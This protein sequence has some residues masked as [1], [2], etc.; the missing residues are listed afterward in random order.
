L[1]ELLPFRHEDEKTLLNG[2]H[3]LNRLI[4]P[5]IFV[6]PILYRNDLYLI[7]TLILITL[8]IGLICRL[9][10][11][12]IFSRLKNIVPF[13]ILITIFI[14]LYV[15]KSNFV[16][17]NIGIKIIIYKE[18]LNLAF[19]LFSRIFG[20]TF[21]FMS[22]YSSFTYSEFIEALSKLRIPTFFI[23]SLMI[24]LHYIPIFAESNKK[25]LEAQEL[26]GKKVTSYWQRLKAHAYIMGKNLVHNMEKSEKLYE[27]LKMRGFAGKLSFPTK[28]VKFY[29]FLI[30][31]GFLLIVIL[32][33][34]I[35][36]L[37]EIYLGAI[38]L[39]L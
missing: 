10:L 9:N 16:E 38:S 34:I 1:E 26:R 28:K 37:E 11:V 27:S 14:P 29:D 5:F 24:M 39:F 2:T 12:R 18:G 19:L 3:P 21:I 6:I 13:I 36:N 30:I 4:L 15:G 22:F 35:I 25:I 23:G 20:I 32:F 8:I 17:L 33:S 31:A 7:Y